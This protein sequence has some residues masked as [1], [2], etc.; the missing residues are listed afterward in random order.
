MFTFTLQENKTNVLLFWNSTW[1]L[2]SDLSS[3]Q[4]QLWGFHWEKCCRRTGSLCRTG[5]GWKGVSHP[6]NFYVF[7]IWS[8]LSFYISSSLIILPQL[9]CSNCISLRILGRSSPKPTSLQRQRG[10]CPRSRSAF[11]SYSPCF[12]KSS[13]LESSTSSKTDQ[14]QIQME[15]E[16]EANKLDEN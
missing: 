4:S 1:N 10:G 16:M 3:F 13:M 15:N 7:K 9:P 2:S 5:R 14:I 6:E 8:F 11:H 12:L